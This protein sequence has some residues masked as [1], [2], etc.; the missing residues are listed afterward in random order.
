MLRFGGS[1]AKEGRREREKEVASI[2]ET[3]AMVIVNVCDKCPSCP[4]ITN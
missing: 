2:D 1:F 4:S 3:G